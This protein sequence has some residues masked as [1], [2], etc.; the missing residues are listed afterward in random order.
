MGQLIIVHCS[1]QLRLVDTFDGTCVL[2]YLGLSQLHFWWCMPPADPCNF[3]TCRIVS[4]GSRCRAHLRTQLSGMVRHVAASPDTLSVSRV[5]VWTVAPER[6]FASSAASPF[7]KCAPNHRWWAMRATATCL[8]SRAV[9]GW[10]GGLLA[11]LPLVPAAG[12]HICHSLACS[13]V[14]LSLFQLASDSDQV[15]LPLNSGS[16]LVQ[17]GSYHFRLKSSLAEIRL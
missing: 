9:T 13:L 14:R 5:K 15:Q 8:V 1:G 6:L 4:S 17:L 3:L 7:R 2:L 10:R 16:Q 12:T 11:W